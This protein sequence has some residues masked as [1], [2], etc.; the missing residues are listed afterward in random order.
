MGR[1]KVGSLT[2]AIGCIALG[3]IIALAQYDKV[4]YAALGYLWPA[5]LIVFGVE[6][7][8][9]LVFRSDVKSRVS[10]WAIVLILLIT[11][12]SAGQSLLSGGS[13]SSLLGN[14]KL[15][16][17][18]GTQEVKSDI[19]AVKISIPNG[20][21]KINGVSGSSLDYE[22]SLLVPGSTQSE[23]ESALEK[24][25][26]VTT[27][28]DTLVMTLDVETNW[29]SSLQFGFYSESPHLNVSVPQDLAVEID[30]SDGSIEALELQSGLTAETSNGTMDLH[31]I[32]G[33]VKAH[34]SNGTLTAKNIQGGVELV[35]SNGAITLDNID[36]SLSAK[37]SN[38]KITIN[39]A[40]TGN[41]KCTSSNGKVILGLPAGTDA[42]V[43]ADTSNGSLNGNVPWERDGDNHGT[44]V[45]GEGT[46]TV[47]V[48][49]SNGSVTVNV[50]E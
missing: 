49:T 43:T 2:A 16:P 19:K 6:M 20:K 3:V 37:S 39:S 18:S 30:T 38:G 24:K 35:S 34:S 27:E 42:R 47:D 26:K 25:W 4:T 50:A 5:L 17:L 32:A 10:G 11:A 21:V 14:M 1:W 7:L 41:W 31:D 23:A 29:L 28:G 9:R 33:G 12:A 36:G 44:A 45:L 22:G 8:G 46:H 48:S 15:A 40:I 13:L